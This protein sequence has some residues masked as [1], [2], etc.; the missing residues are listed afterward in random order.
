MVRVGCVPPGRCCRRVLHRHFHES[1]A[2]RQAVTELSDGAE[3]VAG[4]ANQVSVSSQSLAQGSSEQAAALEETSA[5]SEE[6]NAMALKNSENSRE[7][8]ELV[9]WLATT[10]RA[11][12]PVAGANGRRHERDQARKAI[13]SRKSFG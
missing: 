13:R 11:D 5:S 12:Q 6:I 8:A 9:N 4:A 3:Q 1:R 10:I 7:A 2:L